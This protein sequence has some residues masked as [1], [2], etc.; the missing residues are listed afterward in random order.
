MFQH[1]QNRPLIVSEN[2]KH[3]NLELK[4]CFLVHTVITKVLF[5]FNHF[6]S[7]SC[8]VC[9]ARW[10]TGCYGGGDLRY[11]YVRPW[12]PSFHA[13]LATHPPRHSQ[14]PHFS[15]FSVLKTLLLPQNCKFLKIL[16]SRASKLAKSSVPKPQIGPN[17]SSQGY[18][19]LRNLVHKGHKFC[20]GLFPSP[21]VQHFGLHT[22][23]L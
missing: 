3:T 11:G 5:N 7:I 18:I 15:I 21:S 20:S 10:H 17:F 4:R 19:L 14:D 9:S 8:N 13:L 2:I 1:V 12:R 23:H 6:Q 22:V 16:S